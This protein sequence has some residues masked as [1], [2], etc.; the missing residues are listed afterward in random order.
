MKTTLT[1]AL[2]A[3]ITAGSIV[4]YTQLASGDSNPAQTVAP[5]AAPAEVVEISAAPAA[6]TA[7]A[8]TK[9]NLRV[10]IDVHDISTSQPSYGHSAL[11]RA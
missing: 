4:G 2:T 1:L 11:C 3:T 10:Q 5:S 9:K 8:E 7:T 6:T